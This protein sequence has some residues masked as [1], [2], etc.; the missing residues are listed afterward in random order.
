MTRVVQ[1][2]QE[3]ACL[4]T[5]DSGH[6]SNSS[7]HYTYPSWSPPLATD[8]VVVDTE[9]TL[10]PSSLLSSSCSDI[11]CLEH[12]SSILRQSSYPVCGFSMVEQVRPCSVRSVRPME[13]WLGC[14]MNHLQGWKSV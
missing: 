6:D 12:A 13:K 9:A 3:K 5:R 10:S 11:F 8:V 1:S 4:L 14:S 7:I 2:L